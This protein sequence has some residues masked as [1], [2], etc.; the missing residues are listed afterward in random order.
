MTKSAV[1]IHIDKPFSLQALY[2]G[3]TD[4]AVLCLVDDDYIHHAHVTLFMDGVYSDRLERAVAA[5]NEILH[6]PDQAEAA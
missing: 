3:Q 1:S 2:Q 6:A 4:T 5:F